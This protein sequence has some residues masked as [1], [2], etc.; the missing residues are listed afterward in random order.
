MIAAALVLAAAGAR[1]AAVAELDDLLARSSAAYVEA[2]RLLEAGP[3]L[4]PSTGPVAAV[5]PAR[6]QAECAKA[7]DYDAIL[8]SYGRSWNW[9]EFSADWYDFVYAVVMREVCM[10]V[11]TGA[12][13]SC[14]SPSPLF[15]VVDHARGRAGMGPVEPNRTLRQ[16]C[17]EEDHEARRIKIFAQGAQAVL[18]ACRAGLMDMIPVERRGA[19]CAAIADN[20]GDP[21]RAAAAA[22]SAMDLTGA[23]ELEHI[24]HD[25]YLMEGRL[26]PARECYSPDPFKERMCEAAYAYWKSSEAGAAAA[27]GPNGLCRAM[28]GG[29]SASCEQY[30]LKAKELFCHRYFKVRPDVPRF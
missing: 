7:Y 18:A 13:T 25:F 11:A 22:A 21:E 6:R 23:A 4:V 3:P 15:E 24:K 12:A 20:L 2:E 30:A 26:K 14:A 19:A 1:A 9:G 16:L 28:L 29:G 5:D 10:D 17:V 8:S 27:C